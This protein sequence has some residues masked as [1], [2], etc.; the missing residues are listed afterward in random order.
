MGGGW[1]GTKSTG[2]SVPVVF[3]VRAFLFAD[4][5]FVEDFGELDHFDGVY[6]GVT[7]VE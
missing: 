2:I 4:E 6:E 5:F 7:L 3:V 1:E